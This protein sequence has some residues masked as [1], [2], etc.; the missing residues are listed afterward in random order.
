MDFLTEEIREKIKKDK[1]EKRKE[2]QKLTEEQIN[3]LLKEIIEYKKIKKSN[4]DNK[5]LK[6]NFKKH[7]IINIVE[8]KT[9]ITK[10]SEIFQKHTGDKLQE[11]E[12]I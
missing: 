10:I 5:L 3:K 7:D 6:L 4:D 12:H 2:E 8:D 9:K 11:G 1:I